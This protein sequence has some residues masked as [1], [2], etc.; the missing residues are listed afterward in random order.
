M[1]DEIAT[2]IRGHIP[3]AE[4]HV[5]SPDGVHFQAVV[6]SA[7]FE[8]QP[9]VR[10]HQAVMNALKDQFDSERVH[11]LQ[12]KTFTPDRWLQNKHLYP[13]NG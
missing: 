1:N 4:V 2:I 10:Q 9:L 11:A 13:I 6:V 12:L 8:G 3:D 5:L 7:S